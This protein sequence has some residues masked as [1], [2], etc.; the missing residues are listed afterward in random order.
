MAA[1][2]ER[3]IA[4][5]RT[6][7]EQ[8][9][10]RVV[11]SLRLALAETGDESA[12]GGVKRLVEAEA[13]D[14]TLRNTILQPI[15]PMCVA[16]GDDPAE[17]TFP[18]RTLSLIWRALKDT[19]AEAVEK[20]RKDEYFEA[21]K[22]T[23][24]QDQLVAAAAAGLRERAHP[25]YIAAAELADRGRDDGAKQLIAALEIGAVV[26]HTT[27]RM[28][29]WLAH[30]GGDTTAGARLA[31]KD[32]VA[33][34]DDAG[35]LFFRMLAA[36]MA[37]PWMVMRII[38]AVMDK[39][40]ERYLRD[41]ELAD[42][43]EK[44]LADIDAS[45]AAIG[46]MNA[47]DGPGMGRIGARLAELVVHQIMEMEGSVELPR[48]QGWGLRVVKQRASLAA[49]VEAR[50]KEAERAVIEALP[51]FA[52]RNQRVRHQVPRLSAP[53]E[54]RWVTHATT[55]L[56]FSEEL[57]TTANY[58]GFSTVRNKMVGKLGEYIDHYVE[59]VVD[60]LHTDDVEDR[61]IAA[62]FLECAAD[63]SVFLRGD[64]AA[65]LIRRRAHSALHDAGQRATG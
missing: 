20:L 22:L 28:P 26:R 44:L 62:A 18:A 30:P 38:S 7:V 45:I 42:F 6:L 39:P 59:S 53:P 36:Q 40:T 58:G 34:A 47:A 5:V 46:A 31:Y 11:G 43:G 49:V 3:K 25:D 35:P 4:I 33:I 52:P 64:K 29:E 15:A 27:Q 13:A 61:A 21:H 24:A 19:E 57:R 12:L 48:D 56:A 14:R 65:E 60:L 51:M 37:Q 9:P 63:F 17:L 10:D 41:S 32:A 8:A 2:S 16:G 1:L 50:L 23:D 54:E 55:L